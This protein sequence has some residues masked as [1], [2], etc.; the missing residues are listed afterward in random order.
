M[1]FSHFYMRLYEHCGRQE[2]LA[3]TIAGKQY[4]ATVRD[5][6]NLYKVLTADYRRRPIN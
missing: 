5:V 1:G 2:G 6:H 4:V 3:F